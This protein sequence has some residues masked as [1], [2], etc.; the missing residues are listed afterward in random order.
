MDE[1]GKEDRFRFINSVNTTGEDLSNDSMLESE[2]APYFINLMLSYH[3]D[4]L[5]YAYNM[6]KYSDLPKK[7]QYLYYLNSIRKRKRYTKLHRVEK[8]KGVTL[9][10]DYYGYNMKKSK[11]ALRLLSKEQIEVIKRKCNRGGIDA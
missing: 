6:D 7:C 8:D 2:Y 4:T 1:E 9:I 11:E 5:F 3:K 10:K